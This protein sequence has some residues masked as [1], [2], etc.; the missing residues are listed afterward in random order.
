MRRRATALLL[1]FV[2]G[3]FVFWQIAA[4]QEDHVESSPLSVTT[5]FSTDLGAGCNAGEG[6]TVLFHYAG[7]QPLRGYLVRFALTDSLTR[8]GLPERDI[9]EI[10]NSREPM[11]ESGAEW[12]RTVCSLAK[13]IAGNP[14]TV[15]PKVDV[16]KFAD[17]SNWGSAVLPASHQLIGTFD[18]MDFSVKATELERFVS[19]I[20]PE[21]GPLP[22]DDVE[23]ETIGPLT[24]E[25]G[26]W[27][28]DRGRDMLAVEA[29]NES[30]TPIRGYVFT[31]T[32]LDPDTGTR[33]RRVT[34]KEL[35]THGNPS[36]YLAPGTAWVAGP[37]K[38][39]YLPDGTLASYKI[40]LDLVVFADGTTFGPKKS[41]ESDEVLG[42]FRGI[43][44]ANLL[45]REARADQ[46]Q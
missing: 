2:L 1:A 13:T 34:T 19:P 11:I 37:R 10:R 15:T 3:L 18:G 6:L 25:S 20:P 4:S 27:R 7:T 40:T 28:D 30:A 12:T 23:S 38:F 44:A 29:T 17:G 45:S 8:K 39:S 26:V 46:E 42:M 41:R 35:E 33:I 16:L 9:Q 21:R 36:D 31:E 14:V 24:F 22:V 43:D 5:E 32:F